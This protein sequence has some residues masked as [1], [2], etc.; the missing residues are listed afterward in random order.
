MNDRLRITNARLIDGTGE[1]P[2]ENMSI[3]VE[4]GRIECIKK[5]IVAEDARTI[6]ATGCTVLPGIIDAHV[7]LESVP[8]SYYRNDDE[9]QLWEYRR[10]Q[11]RAYLACGVTTV[12]DYGIS[13]RQL[14]QFH[15]YLS[16]GGIGPRLYALGPILYPPGGY[17]DAVKMPHWGPFRSSGTPAEVVALIDEYAMFDEVIGIKMTLEPGMGP[18][19]IWPIHDAEMRKTIVSEARKRH[20]PIHVHALRPEE[21]QRA[22]EMGAFCLAHAGF[23][24]SQPSE[25]FI[26]EVK[27]RGVY[28]TTTLASTL[29][30]NLYMFNLDKM[31]DPLIKL[32]VPPT[33]LATAQNPEA[34][35]KTMVQMLKIGSPAWMPEVVIKMMMKLMNLRKELTRQYES[36]C[37]AIK[38]MYDAGVPLLVGTD[39]ANWPL[40]LNNFHGPSTILEFE[41][42]QE[43]GLSPMDIIQSATRLPAE[44][45]RLSDL[46]GTVEEGKRADLVIVEGDPLVDL[47]RLRNISL[48]IK[49]GEARTP[50]EWMSQ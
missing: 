43:A 14:R 19:R 42:L 24:R 28:V 46:F 47:R 17:G 31:N 6:D 1:P 11:L 16:G 37:R 12:L 8:G 27:R 44:M 18:S 33:Q 23:F 9:E 39:S 48:S 50:A 20:M 32:T 41:M 10:H 38:T 36:A 26:E 45:M 2:V 15:E 5:E 34:W 22:L 13:V 7:H 49:E 40:F 3:L 35:K 4:N 29:G 25:S 21:Q 30:Q